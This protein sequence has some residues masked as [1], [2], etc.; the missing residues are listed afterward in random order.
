MHLQALV[1]QKRDTVE[2]CEKPSW[3]LLLESYTKSHCERKGSP[4]L[5]KYS[6]LLSG[7]LDSGCSVDVQTICTTPKNPPL[8]PYTF[9]TNGNLLDKGWVTGEQAFTLPNPFLLCM[10]NKEWDSCCSW[11]PCGQWEVQAHGEVESY[12]TCHLVTNLIAR[13]NN[14]QV[15]A[16]GADLIVY[17]NAV[18]LNVSH[19]VQNVA[20]LMTAWNLDRPH[21]WIWHP[22]S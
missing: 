8:Q 10:K 22:R 11:T 2:P 9:G 21:W 15:Q 14:R 7:G 13:P 17:H 12:L 18:G 20:A 4:W 19:E 16:P 6:M 5:S 3:Y 1:H